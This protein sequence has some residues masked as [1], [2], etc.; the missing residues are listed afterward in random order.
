MWRLILCTALLLLAFAEPG[1]AATFTVDS[2]VDQVD[3]NPG[4]GSCSTDGAVCS[5]RAA[6]Q[7]ANALAGTDAIVLPAG[8]FVVAGVLPV[9]SDVTIAGAGARQSI[10][11]GN[12][13]D[14][15]FTVDAGRTA[16]I[17]HMTI[18]DGQAGPSNNFWGGDVQNYGTLTL[19]HVRLTAGDASSGGAVANR[20]GILT[21]LN[22]LLDSNTALTGGGDGGAVL[23]VSEAGPATMVVRDSTITANSARFAGAI[24]NGGAG[25]ALD[26]RASTIVGNVETSGSGGGARGVSGAIATS[27]TLPVHLRATIVQD[28]SS[29]V[30]GA[31]QNCQADVLSAGYVSDG[32]LAAPDE[33]RSGSNLPPIAGTGD[34]SA[35][36]ALSSLA[37][38]GGETD[39]VAPTAPSMAIDAIPV[40]ACA[41]LT[42]QRDVG[43]PQGSGCDIGA[44]ELAAAGSIGSSPVA[45]PP[46]SDGD[47]VVDSA[48][49]CPGNA[50]PTQ[51]DVDKDGIGDACDS[52]NGLRRPIVGKTFDARVIDEPGLP[53]GPVYIKY[54]P[55]AKPASAAATSALAGIGKGFVPLNG[56]AYVPIGSVIDAA[57]G[58]LELT[59]SRGTVAGLQRGTF[60]QGVFAVLQRRARVAT[61]DLRLSGGSFKGCT[62]SASAVTSGARAASGGKAKTKPKVVRSLWGRD[63]GGHFRS[64]GKHSSGTVRGTR[65]LTQDRCDGT[66]TRVVTGKVAVQDFGAHRTVLV[67]SGHSYLARAR[68]AA[69][70]HRSHG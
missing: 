57:R 1:Q 6:V 23:N 34:T 66:L 11:E 14:R 5:L 28:N 46:D 64:V 61:T 27:S 40:P 69:A 20:S 9:S 68:I 15:V 10:V 47:G 32:Y 63:A 22:S 25:A 16:T 48:D 43:R 37:D 4:D 33:C 17:S 38:N 26:I 35:Q 58:T 31:K 7:E 67:S 45:G 12:Q 30:G 51:A 42:D 39:T 2:A 18:R 65:W 52:S 60:Y 54:P 50:N 29:P 55:G 36:M 24:N 70:K 44:V 53:N 56:A 3:L 8:K 41:T 59:S 21:I 19:D 62:A 13:L 49:N